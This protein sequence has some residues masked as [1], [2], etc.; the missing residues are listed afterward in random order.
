LAAVEQY[1]DPLMRSCHTLWPNADVTIHRIQGGMTN[2]NYL[3]TVDSA[4][5]FFAQHQIGGEA[6]RLVGIDRYRQLATHQLAAGLGI[7][8]RLVHANIDERIFI[9]EFIDGATLTPETAREPAVITAVAQLLRSLHEA[10]PRPEYDAWVSHPFRGLWNTAALARRH[11]PR[12]VDEVEPALALMRRF[13][14]ARGTWEPVLTHIDLLCGNLMI[15][16]ERLWL[17]DWEYAGLGDPLYDLGDYAGKNDL[18]VESVEQLLTDYFGHPPSARDVAIVQLYGIDSLLRE[19]LWAMGM[20]ALADNGFDH[21][22]YSDELKARALA[23]AESSAAVA[24]LAKVES[25]A[26]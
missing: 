14:N 21:A 3:V 13:E 24:Q 6:V 5:C 2:N 12:G 18:P 15:T 25:K 17:I 23:A 19:C 22:G 10:A 9:T 1:P 16:P 20:A 8:P 26:A 7:A 11:Q 4:R